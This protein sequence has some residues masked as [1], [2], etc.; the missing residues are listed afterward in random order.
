MRVQH[1]RRRVGWIASAFLVTAGVAARHSQ[2][3]PDTLV[4]RTV[5]GIIVSEVLNGE[6]LELKVRGSSEVRLVFQSYGLRAIGNEQSYK[7]PPAVIMNI[8]R[9]VKQGDYVTIN[10]VYREAAQTYYGIAVEKR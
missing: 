6:N 10:A 9:N 3:A 2:P 7:L 1:I 4:P 5:E 8:E